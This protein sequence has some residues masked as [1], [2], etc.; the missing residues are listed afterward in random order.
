MKTRNGFV[1]GLVSGLLIS[2]AATWQGE[3]KTQSSDSKS[4]DPWLDEDVVIVG[5]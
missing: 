5:H 4:L 2:A 1:A 3:P